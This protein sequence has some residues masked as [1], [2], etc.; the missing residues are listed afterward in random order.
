MSIGLAKNT[1]VIA[2]NVESTE[3]TYVAPASATDGYIQPLE[4]GFELTPS[5]ELIERN[6]LTNSIGKVSPRT[7]TKSVSGTLPVEFRA[8]GTEGGDVDFGILLK[9]LLG[10]TRAIS[11][12]TTTK[13]SGN[14]GSSLAIED[15]DISKFNVGD[16]IIVKE[17]GLHKMHAITSVTT[18][19]GAASIGITPSKASGS[20]SNSVVIS[21]TKMYYTANSGHPTFSASYFWGNEILQKAMGCRVN[22]MSI[23]NFSTGQVASF[24]F[25]FEGLT[26]DE[27]NGSAAHTPSYDSGLPPLILRACIHQNG[28]DIQ[29][30]DFALSVENDIG[31]LTS[32]CSSTGRISSRVTSRS[33]TG[34]LN[35]YKDDTTYDQ[36]TKFDQNTS[37]SLFIEAYNPSA[38]SGE[39][40]MGSAVGIYLPNCIITEY[41]VQDVEGILTDNLSFSATR[42]SSGSSEEIYIGFI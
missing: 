14:T 6:I 19:L 18:T 37:F 36:F 24:N 17:S 25:G 31:F 10:A 32:T 3:G 28:T 12:T 40:D 8:S 7:G 41:N 35:P 16:I 4:D 2:V 29:L 38:V 9:A 42:G 1:T 26:Y 13:A 33:V 21:K 27:T 23:D 11:T 34:T 22:S 30:N 39:I 20:Y 5:K 15:A